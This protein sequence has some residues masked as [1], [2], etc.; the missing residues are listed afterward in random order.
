MEAQKGLQF[1]RNGTAVFFSPPQP[2]ESNHQK[3]GASVRFVAL[4]ALSNFTEEHAVGAFDTCCLRIFVN[5][6]K[7]IQSYAEKSIV[8]R[9]FKTL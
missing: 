7:P 9:T 2:I 8:Q 1:I 6:I 5:K 4:A 3:R